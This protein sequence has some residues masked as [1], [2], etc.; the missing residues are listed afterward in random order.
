MRLHRA[1]MMALLGCVT[2]GCGGAPAE[3]RGA[4]NDSTRTANASAPRDS[5]ATVEVRPAT[6][7]QTLAAIREPGS[8][9]VLVSVW[10]TW[11]AP[12]RE[13]FPD[14]MR[15]GREYRDRGVRLLLVSA[16]FDTELPAVRRFLAAHGVDFPTLIKNDADMKF[17]NGLE[18]R[19]SGAIPATILY[20]GSGRKLWFHE[21][22]V[23]YDTLNTRIAAA[24]ASAATPV[25]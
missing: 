17:I 5:S 15:V 7:E 12:C 22:Q 14:V 1:A 11:C 13:E 19:W 21:G 6:L 25:P 4:G 20:D 8:R 9:L 16:D 3:R 2:I 10:A 18:P 23:A 24:L